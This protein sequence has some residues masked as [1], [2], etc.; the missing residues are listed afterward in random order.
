MYSDLDMD[1]SDWSCELEWSLKLLIWFK[2]QD[3]LLKEGTDYSE[4]QYDIIFDTDVIVNETETIQNC[5]TSQGVISDE[6]VASNHPWT[7]N[8]KKEV[9]NMHDDMETELDLEAT[10]KAKTTKD[11]DG[12]RTPN[13]LT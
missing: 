7:R 13:P 11:S 2:Q 5:F 4:C 3:L 6:T 1:C 9:E 12:Q 8:A 10:Y